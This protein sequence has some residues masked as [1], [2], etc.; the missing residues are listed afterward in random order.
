MTTH[1]RQARS[2]HATWQQLP[3]WAKLL[4]GLSGSIITLILVW[5]F[6]LLPL[7]WPPLPLVAS[8]FWQSVYSPDT[9]R[10]FLMTGFRAVLSMVIGFGFAVTF[11]IL[12]GRTIWGWC[13]FFILLLAMQKIPA[14]AMVHVFV[15][16]KLGIGFAMTVAL[17]STVV[18]TFTWLVLH[19]RAQ[20]LDEKE[21][22]SLKVVGFKSWQLSLY[23]LLPHMGSA[24]GGSARLAMSI[25][26]VMVILGEWQGLWTDG[27]HSLWEYGLGSQIIRNYDSVDSSARILAA[28]LWLGLLGILLDVFVQG[29]LQLSRMLTGIDFRR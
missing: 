1:L 7:N 21:V 9:Y 17:A 12:T 8:Y 2:F 28:C 26:I 13:A 27:S 20:T 16:S 3:I 18:T 15:E 14:I 10:A 29:S 19:H 23:G 24:I 5:Q 6:V 25:S 11:A 4:C 22:F